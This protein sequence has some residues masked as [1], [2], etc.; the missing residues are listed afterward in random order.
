MSVLKAP[1]QDDIFSG[2]YDPEDIVFLLN[3]L[4][5]HTTNVEEKEKAIQSGQK[6]YS[7]MISAESP[8]SDEY[9]SIF[10]Q[11]MV[12]G[13]ERFGH[14]VA[15]LALALSEQIE[16]PIT[17]ASLVRAGAPAGILLNRALKV[18]G[19][20]VWHFGI[21]IIRDHG[22]DEHAMKYILSQRPA[23]GLVFVDGWTGKGAISS[24][25]EK[26]YRDFSTKEARLIVLA[27]PCGRAWMAASGD[28]WLIPSG[29]L[30]STVSGLISRTI[31][32]DTIRIAG[33]FHGCKLWN[34]LAPHDISKTFIDR[35]WPYVLKGLQVRKK[36]IWSDA[37]RLRHQTTSKAAIDFVAQRHGVTNP[38]RIKPGIAEATRAVLRRMPEMVYLSSLQDPDLSAM[39]HLIEKQSI[40]FE[41][42]PEEIAPYRA[43]TLIKK[44][45]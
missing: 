41:I 4:D 13:A 16:G 20:D 24:Q 1:Y 11:A 3:P 6:H 19:R 36:A 12:T 35:V 21:S 30:G 8:P 18:L 34:D 22:L 31:L 37:D 33:S 38:N 44:V 45:S 14:D 43:I 23:E 17:L 29:I 28:D 5:I 32:N 10:E 9:K 15:S 42:M 27:D 40:P 2:S 26:S 39:V 7:E 25:L